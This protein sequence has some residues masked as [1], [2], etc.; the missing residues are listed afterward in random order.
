MTIE[1]L[2]QKAHT[3]H[4]QM[5][6]EEASTLYKKFL[7]ANPNHLDANYLLGTLF[8]QTNRLNEAE[9]YL[10]KAA[11]LQPTSPMIN[12]NLGN[13]YKAQKRYDAAIACF[14][15]A[16]QMKPELPQAYFG[17][18]SVLDVT[19]ENQQK[20]QECYLRALSLDSK[21]PEVH[22]AIGKIYYKE[23]KPEALHH[24]TT[25]QR[26]NP[27]L[28]GIS[29]N[30][31]FACLRYNKTGEAIEHLKAAAIESPNDIEVRYFLVVAQGGEPDHEL[32]IAYVKEEFDGLALSFDEL[33]YD[34]LKY[35]TPSKLVD[36]L[37]KHCGDNVVFPSAADLGC[38]TGLSGTVLRP[39]TGFL[40]GIDI[41][42]NMLAE[43]AKKGCY[44][45]LLHGSIIEQL[46]SVDAKFDLFMAADVLIYIGALD[47]LFE[48]VQN[49]A[50]KGALLL[51]S[52]ENCAEAGFILKPSGR[53]AHNSEYILS[54]AQK[55]SFEIVSRESSEIRAE[56]SDWIMGELYLVKLT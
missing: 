50:Q 23:G 31:G 34:K 41:S 56:G 8:A 39:H 29:K 1:K 13:V 18:G 35:R 30:L 15:R 53:Y 21:I 25:A 52:T 37:K 19:G 6:F 10:A 40:V 47:Q 20:A 45:K 16:I 49:A 44:D 28:P 7:K 12:V 17:L 9:K 26:L 22:Q 33:L 24:L 3:K 55:Y 5:K 46:Y 48:T 36:L 27:R 2:F 32:K 54:L 51:F 43:A 14:T 38:G 11:D 4:L 42:E